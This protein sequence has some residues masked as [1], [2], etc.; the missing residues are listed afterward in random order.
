MHMKKFYSFL[1]LSS[2]PLITLAQPNLGSGSMNILPGET[3]SYQRGDYMFPPEDGEI[4]AIWDYTAFNSMMVFTE[5]YVSPTVGGGMGSST[6]AIDY[7][8]GTYIYYRGTS[9]KFEQV[10]L[11]GPQSS[12][13]CNG[14]SITAFEYPFTY[15][16]SFSDTYSCSGQSQGYGFTRTGT[17][18]G[19]GVGY[20]TLQLP[21]GSV[22][23]VL[24]I[25]YQQ[26]HTDV[27]AL[28]DDDYTATIHL[29]V[30]PGVK[31]PLLT[32]GDLNGTFTTQT[33][34]ILL[35][36]NFVGMAEAMA[37]DI[38]IELMP[39]PATTSLDVM[40]STTGQNMTYEIF[41]GLGRVVSTSSIT[42]MAPGITRNTI[43]VS[44][45]PAGNYQLRI[46]DSTGSVGMKRFM[47]Q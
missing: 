19:E 36:A 24:L 46:T 10:G 42:A 16:S 29:F 5:N 40:H 45:L 8:G 23:N 25:R 12:L 31:V 26:A 32:I 14:N 9:T 1:A 39:N 2:L 6:V 43:D 47:V 38:G 21:Y 13:N 33:Y 17:M 35:N 34:S 15:G 27:G 41:D 20:G 7:G 37:Q 4:N 18:T 3:Y 22:S 28:I 30:K 44:T 11:T